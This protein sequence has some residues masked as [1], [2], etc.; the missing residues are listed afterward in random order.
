MKSYKK[1]TLDISCEKLFN[2][3]IFQIKIHSK[4]KNKPK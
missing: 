4:A 3:V 2:K 1:K